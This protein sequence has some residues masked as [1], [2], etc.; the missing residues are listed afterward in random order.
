MRVTAVALACIAGQLCFSSAL[1]AQAVPKRPIRMLV[2]ATPGGPSDAHARLV[3]PRMS[4]MLGQ[5]IIVDNRASSN[6]VVANEIAAR[7]TP[8]GSTLIVG[9][10]GTH[11]VNQTLYRK[12]SYDCVRDFAP[13]TQFS[14]TGLLVATHPRLP[15]GSMPELTAHARREPGRVNVGIPGSTGQLAGDA[16]W[17]AL[18]IRMNNVNY[19]GSSPAEIALLSG[20]VDIVFLTPLAAMHHLASGRLKA[21]GITSI[22]RHPAL[23][24]VPTVA[25]QGV[26]GYDFQYW[27]GLF[28][29]AGTPPRLL[30]T[31][32][33]AAI[34][35][36]TSADVRDRLTQ[37]GLIVRGNAPQA[38]ADIV[39]SDVERY[40]KVI[41][42]Q[43]IERL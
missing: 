27:N 3:A 18:G 1:Y 34:A 11:A 32:H 16:L 40:R 15:A 22:E 42:E 14:T 28:A 4:E 17:A 6:G 5:T 31:L 21:L 8:D 43:N 13:I 2:G 24:N 38:F 29:P 10:S 30:R 39:K 37:L 41:L 33:E 25:E 35:A 36:L 23:P 26:P 7:A 19:K 12:L 20:E 9:N